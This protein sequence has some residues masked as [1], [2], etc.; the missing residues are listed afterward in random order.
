MPGTPHNH[1]ERF[2]QAIAAG[3]LSGAW[4]AATHMTHVTLDRALRLVLLMGLEEDPGAERAARRF[5]IRFARERQPALKQLTKLVDALD[6]GIRDGPFGI[7]ARE[8]L[9]DLARRLAEDAATEGWSGD[10]P[11][12]PI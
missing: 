9:E 4:L 12:P 2:D 10:P 5:V 1:V 8:A 3:E 11:F 6:H 7:D